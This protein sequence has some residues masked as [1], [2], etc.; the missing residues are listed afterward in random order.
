MTRRRSRP[1]GHRAA[2]PTG[3]VRFRD[4]IAAT[5]ALATIQRNDRPGRDKLEAR[6]YRC[7]SCGGWHL[8]SG[9]SRV[10]R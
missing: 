5:L 4:R 1:R 3:K 2:C 10:A 6:V 8:T 7:P 9:K